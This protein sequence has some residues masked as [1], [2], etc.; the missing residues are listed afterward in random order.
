M[1][2]WLLKSGEPVPTD[3]GRQRLHRT[4]IL[5]EVLAAN[6]CDVVWWTSTFR[7]ADKQFRYN[8]TTWEDVG[9]RQRI[10]FL[11]TRPYFKNVSF[12]RI[13]F[14]R[15]IANEFQQEA[16]DQKQPDII[17]AAYPIPELAEAS[18]RYAKERGIPAVVDIRDLWPEIWMSAVPSYAKPIARVALLPFHHQSRRAL[19]LFDGICG[20]TDEMVEWGLKKAGRRR[21]KWDRAFPLA[22]VENSYAEL[23]KR[24][25]KAFW[26][27][28]LA[29]PPPPDLRLCFFGNIAMR[30][31]RIDVMIDAMRKLPEAVRDRTQLVL[32]GVGEDFEA[33]RASAADL[34][35]VVV[36][37]WVTGPQIEVLASRSH[38]GIL[39]YP[40]G[41]DF[42]RAVPNKAVDYL[43]HGLPILA[44]LQ[45]PTSRLIEDEGCGIVYRETDPDD[46][47]RAIV[48]MLNDPARVKRLSDSAR[49]AFRE[50]FRATEVY[51]RLTEMLRELASESRSER[52][53][54]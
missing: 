33:V 44:S 27:A 47:A 34:P 52:P 28:R 13:L 23:D 10:C 20:P 14:N 40:S 12:D 42:I 35:Q 2:I 36:P 31:A 16:L 11:H 25:A 49:R 50:H 41:F 6:G 30:R 54:A 48:D 29:G 43:A 45:G 8:G 32:C 3:P 18:A 7:H 38:A 22:Y 53:S 39:P 5:A 46:L 1:R 17:F 4:G 15:E 37:G 26:D 9:D 19:K 24:A 21:G 51:G